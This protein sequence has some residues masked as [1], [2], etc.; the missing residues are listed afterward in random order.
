M[1][2]FADRSS[3]PKRLDCVSQ[4]YLFKQ[5]R[6]SGLQTLNITVMYFLLNILTF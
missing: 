4:V 3:E 2:H 5:I 1:S 6:E